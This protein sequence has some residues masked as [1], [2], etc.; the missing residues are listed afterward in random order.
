MAKTGLQA[1]H[2][3]AAAAAAAP[4][5]PQYDASARP[6]GSIPEPPAVHQWT[7]AQPEHAVYLAQNQ[8]GNVMPAGAPNP[9]PDGHP[10]IHDPAMIQAAQLLIPGDYQAARKC[11][12]L[13]RHIVADNSFQPC[14]ICPKTSTISKNSLHSWIRLVCRLS[15][16]PVRERQPSSMRSFWK[17]LRRRRS[18]LRSNQGVVVV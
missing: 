11:F 15:G 4:I 5:S 7:A 18:C 16:Y 3:P 2:H 10:G 12:T 6:V 14:L 8:P 13:S 9:V 17:I 1:P